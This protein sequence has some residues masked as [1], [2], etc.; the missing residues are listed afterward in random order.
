MQ[1]RTFTA[2]LTVAADKLPDDL[3]R[4]IVEAIRNLPVASA[5][6]SLEP[7]IHVTTNM[8][9]HVELHRGVL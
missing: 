7:G 9:K 2:L 8:T 3:E 4:L 6:A 1:S 5:T